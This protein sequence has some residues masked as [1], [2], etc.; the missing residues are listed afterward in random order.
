MVDRHEKLVLRQA[1]ILGDE[2]PSMFNGFGFKII[3]KTK[4]TQHFEK[5]VMPRRV[6][7]I[8]QIIMLF[9]RNSNIE[10]EYQQE[11]S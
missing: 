6:T 7:D 5:S 11:T 8:V 9:Q 10:R 4:I 2:F 1:K 3:T